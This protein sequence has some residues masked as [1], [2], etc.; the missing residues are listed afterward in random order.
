MRVS[1]LILKKLAALTWIAGAMVLLLKGAALVIEARE[2]RPGSLLNHVPLL[3][4]PVIGFLKARFLFSNSCRKNLARI[5][6]LPDPK[7]WQFFRPGFFLSLISMVLLGVCLSAFPPLIFRYQWPC[8]EVFTLFAAG[9][10][11]GGLELSNDW[12]TPG[13]WFN[14]QYLTPC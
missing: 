8:W 9:K 11:N 14:R 5:D 1:P 7:L 3:V 10:V 6:T 2:L 13:I 4:A 12:K